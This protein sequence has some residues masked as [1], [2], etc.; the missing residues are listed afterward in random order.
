MI[1]LFVTRL[2]LLFLCQSIFTELLFPELLG[3][4]LS[5]TFFSDPNNISVI[6][7]SKIDPSHVRWIRW[8]CCTRPVDVQTFRFRDI[9]RETSSVKCLDFVKQAMFSR[10][11]SWYISRY[12]PQLGCLSASLRALAS[13]GIVSRDEPYLFRPELIT[14][15]QEQVLWVLWGERDN[16]VCICLSSGCTPFRMLIQVRPS[17]ILYKSMTCKEVMEKIFLTLAYLGPLRRGVHRIARG[18]DLR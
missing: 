10:R 17:Q 13:K 16:C 7:Y 12:Q 14:M 3:S 6:P 4:I 18:P 9:G 1:Q 11:I 15:D 5:L 2:S 8:P